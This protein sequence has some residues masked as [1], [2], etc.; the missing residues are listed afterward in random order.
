MTEHVPEPADESASPPKKNREHWL[1][2]GCL[3]SFFLFPCLMVSPVAKMLQQWGL[4]GFVKK[5]D[6]DC[7]VR[8]GKMHKAVELYAADYDESYPFADLWIDTTWRYGTKKSPDEESESIYRCP[9]IAMTRTGDFGYGFNPTLSEAKKATVA[10]PDAMWMIFD[11]SD[12]SRNAYG[13][14][15][16]LFPK[17]PR[18]NEGK[19][20]NAV[21]VGGTVKEVP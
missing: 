20:N 19:N 2:L 3:A 21:T 6:A 7:K 11:S 12:L 14:P 13:K 10:D 9:D 8:L 18:H 5:V 17:P 16:E 1:M 15:E 4:G